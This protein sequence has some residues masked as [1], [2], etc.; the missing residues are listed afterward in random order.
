M[1]LKKRNRSKKQ[2]KMSITV[3]LKFY[4]NEWHYMQ[5][6]VL[7]SQVKINTLL[8]RKQYYCLIIFVLVAYLKIIDKL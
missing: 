1:G 4:N 6:N 3:T 2:A 8:M 5:R 7:I